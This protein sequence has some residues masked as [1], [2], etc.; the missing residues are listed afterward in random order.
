MLYVINV[1]VTGRVEG[2]FHSMRLTL[3]NLHRENRALIRY[4][5]VNL[6]DEI[7]SLQS[8]NYNVLFAY[9][10]QHERK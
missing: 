10:P 8:R 9:I 5:V 4:T 3:L 2:F 1:T 6:N 7:D